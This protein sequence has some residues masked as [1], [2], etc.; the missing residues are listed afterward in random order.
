MTDPTVSVALVEDEPGMRDR[1]SRM[2]RA[3]PQL[4]LVH[5]AGTAK[6]FLQWLSNNPV[7][8]ALV[9]LGLPDQSGLEVIRAC[10]GMQPACE[11]M[12]ITMFG[13]ES[14]MLRAFEAGARGYLL[15]DGTEKHFSQH[16]L[17]LHRGGSPMSPLI[18]RQLLMRWHAGP[19]SNS[20]ASVNTSAAHG[21][22]AISGREL[23]VLDLVARGFTYKETGVQ[24]GIAVT[25]V[26]AHVRNI[27]GKLDVHN[28]A[29]AIYEARKIGW[30]QE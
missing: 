19:G 18:A 24:L 6:E 23:E 4:E 13:D 28:K 7:S 21:V 22:E 8:V 3:N 27:Y 17:N 2:I 16:I 9:D 30:L 12:V 15:K 11:V 20:T 5:A 10:R 29:E 14:N 25:T 26:H 1:L